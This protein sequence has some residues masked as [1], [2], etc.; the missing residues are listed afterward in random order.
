M[1]VEPLYRMKVKGEG[2]G[3]GQADE[4]SPHCSLQFH[5]H[6]PP[7]PAAATGGWVG[8]RHALALDHLSEIHN[9]PLT[10]SNII[11]I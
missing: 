4:D 2:I 6:S 3:S 8:C 5:P 9:P 10:M 1:A 11:H 7:N